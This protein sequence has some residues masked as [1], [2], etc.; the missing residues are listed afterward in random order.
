MK[1]GRIKVDV[2]TDYLGRLGELLTVLLLN[3]LH[4]A[5]GLPHKDE[6]RRW[7]EG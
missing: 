4:P 7:V 1:E 2:K 5:V 6:G 3:L